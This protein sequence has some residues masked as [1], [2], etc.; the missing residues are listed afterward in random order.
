MAIIMT[1][2]CGH[3]PLLNNYI[4]ITNL[5]LTIDD[6]YGAFINISVRA[7]L[8]QEARDYDKLK[9]YFKENNLSLKATNEA[10][11]NFIDT[12]WNK[13]EVLN[14]GEATLSYPVEL[15]EV[16]GK[17]NEEIF[18]KAYE[19]IRANK[20][21]W[22]F[23]PAHSNNVLEDHIES[24]EDFVKRIVTPFIEKFNSLGDK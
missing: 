24:D 2:E 1:R 4:K 22:G 14:V 5:T 13:P 8:S 18:A 11:S 16:S 12:Y 17:T 9:E 10:Q 3:G 23:K 15:K 7:Y 6:R 21:G 19:S 20:E